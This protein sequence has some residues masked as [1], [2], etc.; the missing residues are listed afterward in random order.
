MNEMC[1]SQMD[2]GAVDHLTQI[3][4]REKVDLPL[5]FFP[6]YYIVITLIFVSGFTEIVSL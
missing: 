3:K 2:G 6:S 4:D 1:V 5:A